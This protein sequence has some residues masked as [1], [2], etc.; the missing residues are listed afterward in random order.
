MH[1]GLYIRSYA[2]LRSS[3]DGWQRQWRAGG[4][5]ANIRL[6]LMVRFK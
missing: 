4:Q 5:G 2:L 1:S 3:K 6:S